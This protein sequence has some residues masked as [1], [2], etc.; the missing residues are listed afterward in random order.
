MPYDIFGN[1]YDRHLREI[2]ERHDRDLTL[3]L[4][5]LFVGLLFAFII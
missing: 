3:F 5:G 1:P 2:E 4:L